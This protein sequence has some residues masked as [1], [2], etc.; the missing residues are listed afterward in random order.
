MA[1]SSTE[2]SYSDL[3]QKT[4]ALPSVRI[5]EVV[6]QTAR[7]D[8]QKRFY[9]A[10]LGR[11]WSVENDP[12]AA[13]AIAG[14]HGDGGKQVHASRIRSCFMILDKD[15]AAVPCGQL[16]ALFEIPGVTLEIGKDPASIICSSSI[17][18]WPILSSASRSSPQP[19]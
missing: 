7:F 10:I 15:A 17:R 2:I 13:A 8:E 12:S 4:A 16:F 14:E 18:R 5:A 11:A 6:L 3:A 9:S 1:Q 19:A